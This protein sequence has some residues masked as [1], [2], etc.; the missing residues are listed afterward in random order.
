VQFRR[1]WRVHKW[2]NVQ[3]LFLLN[4][5]M[6]FFTKLK[7]ESENSN[8]LV[9]IVHYLLQING[10]AGISTHIDTFFCMKFVTVW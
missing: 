1:S 5:I 3:F 8:K 10:H 4:D 7:N 9:A 2:H 6:F